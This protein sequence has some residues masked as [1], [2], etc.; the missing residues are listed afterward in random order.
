MVRSHTIVFK[1]DFMQIFYCRTHFKW[2]FLDFR[3]SLL[4]LRV[5]LDRNTRP[6]TNFIGTLH[7]CKKVRQSPKPNSFQAFAHELSKVG[8]REGRETGK[9][10]ASRL[11]ERKAAQQNKHLSIWGT[12]TRPTFT[13]QVNNA[14]GGSLTFPD[15]AWFS[16]KVDSHYHALSVHARNV[17]DSDKILLHGFDISYTHYKACSVS[18]TIMHGTF[19]LRILGKNILPD[20]AVHERERTCMDGYCELPSDTLGW[21]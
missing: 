21:H 10:Y 14:G 12:K 1:Y 5:R 16:M 15:N 8:R 19:R 3:P 17:S 7:E 11:I 13:A 4:W 18:G 6:K 20:H 9:T 2:D